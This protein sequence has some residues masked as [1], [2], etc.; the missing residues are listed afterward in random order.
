MPV[1][2][3][4]RNDSEIGAEITVVWGYE[5]HTIVLT[6]RNWRR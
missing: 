3:R 1:K 4:A 2:Q 5:P 6:P